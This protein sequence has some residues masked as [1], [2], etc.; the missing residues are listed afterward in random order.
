MLVAHKLGDNEMS[1]IKIQQSSYVNQIAQFQKSTEMQ[2]NIINNEDS[3][4]TDLK[5]EL[6]TEPEAQALANKIA[7]KVVQ[8]KDNSFLSAQGE[9]DEAKILAL[10]QDD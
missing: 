3:V 1:S 4:T 2:K 9:L 7:S 5:P 6:T 10:L 8:S